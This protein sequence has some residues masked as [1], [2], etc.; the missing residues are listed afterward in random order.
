MAWLQEFRLLGPVE[1]VVE[2]RPVPLP[3]AK[4][5]A[6]LAVLLLNRNRVVSVGRLVDDL[7]GE[8]PPETATKALQGYVWQ[9]RKALG[10]ERRRTKPP[11]DSLRVEDGE[12]AL[13]RFELLVRE[14]RELLGAGDWKAAAKRFDEALELWRGSP[15]VEFHAEPF[16]RDAGARLE[17][18]RLAALEERIEADLALGRPARL[19]P[20]REAPRPRRARSRD[21]GRSAD[22]RRIVG[23]DRLC[24]RRAALLRRQARELPHPIAR[25]PPRRS[26]GDRRRRQLQADAAGGARSPEPRP[27]QP[28]KPAAAGRCALGPEHRSG[29]PRVRP[30]PRVCARLLHRRRA[31]QRLAGRPQALRPARPQ[32]RPACREDGRRDGDTDQA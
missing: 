12:L 2:G 23:Q 10:T 27:A 8:E 9:L 5:R 29:A 28:A 14:G 17:D 7:W 15:F 19:V 11:G 1:A 24:Q 26:R 22:R 3:A 31:L 6:L 32:R 18:A 25:R 13:D 20:E 30:A 21:R 4:P 16:A